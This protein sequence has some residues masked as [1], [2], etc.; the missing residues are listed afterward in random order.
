MLEV[1]EVIDNCFISGQ[2]RESARPL[3]G[4]SLSISLTRSRLSCETRK[5]DTQTSL[6]LCQGENNDYYLII[7]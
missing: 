5:N 4:W 2:W 6:L 3:Y 7:N 1:Y